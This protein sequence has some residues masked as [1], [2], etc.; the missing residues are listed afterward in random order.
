MDI[1]RRHIVALGESFLQFVG[2]LGGTVLKNLVA[3]FLPDSLDH[4]GQS[5]GRKGGRMRISSREGVYFAQVNLFE[6][7]PDRRTHKVVRIS[8]KQFAVV[9][10]I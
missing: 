5:V 8:G 2:S 9:H 4:R 10:L 6:D 1:I 7:V 3:I